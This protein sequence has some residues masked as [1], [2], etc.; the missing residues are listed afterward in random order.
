MKIILLDGSIK[1]P[2]SAMDGDRNLQTSK[3]PL[4]SQA[5]SISLFTSAASNQRGCPED[6]PREVW[7]RLPEG[8][9]RQ[10]S[11]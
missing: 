9:R 5:Q 11:S 1:N 6:S 3:A 4:K 10:S 8:Q 2:P 7:D